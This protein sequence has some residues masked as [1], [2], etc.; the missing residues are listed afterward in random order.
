M[1]FKLNT[2]A[3]TPHDAR[4]FFPEFSR[5]VVNV[6]GTEH[7]G[8]CTLDIDDR[9]RAVLTF[10]RETVDANERSVGRVFRQ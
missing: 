3:M 1:K 8:H 7:S 9:G 10:G 2:H 6:N 5:L 4:R